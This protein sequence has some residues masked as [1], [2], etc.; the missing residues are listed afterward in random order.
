MARALSNNVNNFAFQT[1]PTAAPTTVG[2]VVAFSDERGISLKRARVRDV[3]GDGI[4]LFP[5]DPKKRIKFP[6]AERGL[7]K[8]SLAI[9][10][11][12]NIVFVNT[13]E[14]VCELASE[15]R[16]ET[17]RAKRR[18][19]DIEKRI[20]ALAGTSIGSAETSAE[21]PVLEDTLCRLGD[22]YTLKFKLGDRLDAAEADVTFRFTRSIPY[23]ST[24]TDG[25]GG[26]GVV[27]MSLMSSN[28][29][30]KAFSTDTAGGTVTCYDAFD[31]IPREYWPVDD[32]NLLY[33]PIGINY[34]TAPTRR[35]VSLEIVK[36]ETTG[37]GYVTTDERRAS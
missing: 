6:D 4:T 28:L 3:E 27:F 31:N 14:Q 36:R 19:M 24:T 11:D 25:V 12:G 13:H 21:I 1:D 9:D 5:G 26:G 16:T 22:T 8:Y 15:L 29:A 32:Y 17:N 35:V 7:E 34:P 30:Q 18:E 37:A 20:D 23:L 2:T 10:C 33:H